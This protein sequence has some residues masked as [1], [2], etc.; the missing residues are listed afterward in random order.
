MNPIPASLT[1]GVIVALA[2]WR[3]GEMISID[4]VIG[5]AGTA[6]FLAVVAQMSRELAQAFGTLA[7]VGVA[8]YQVPQIFEAAGL[9]NK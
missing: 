9:D 4:N 8:L 7:V 1:I 2:R 6:V 3:K 5:V